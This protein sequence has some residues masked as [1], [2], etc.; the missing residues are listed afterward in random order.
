MVRNQKQELSL[1]KHIKGLTHKLKIDSLECMTNKVWN[2]TYM[3]I[4]PTFLG[5]GIFSFSSFIV[6]MA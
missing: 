2:K 1:Q 5:T 6:F 3:N 4:S